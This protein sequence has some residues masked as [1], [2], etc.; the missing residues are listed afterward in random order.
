M[1]AETGKNYS[2]N[3]PMGSVTRMK[4]IKSVV[5]GDYRLVLHKGGGWSIWKRQCLG[6]KCITFGLCKTEKQAWYEV[7]MVVFGIINK[8]FNKFQKMQNKICN[9]LDNGIY[10][11]MDAS[12]VE[13]VE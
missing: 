10:D 11:W 1:K 8:N 7:K 3:N 4:Q 6:G 12:N 2:W 13:I 5:V 9:L